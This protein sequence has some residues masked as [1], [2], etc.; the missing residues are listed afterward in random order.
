MKKLDLNIT[1]P[2]RLDK[3][4]AVS[5]GISRGAAAKAVES[6]A[7]LM[8]AAPAQTKLKITAE[9][10]ITYSPDFF[11]PKQADWDT[12]ELNILHET[13]DLLILNKQA[14]LLIHP[15]DSSHEPTLT[16][17]LVK[18]L[19]AISEVGENPIRPGLVHRLDKQASGVLAVAKTQEMFVHLKNAFKNREVIK[20]Y[21]VLVYGVIE[22]DEDEV[23]FP[24]ARSKITGR[25]A[26]K[27][28][29]QGGKEAVTNFTVKKRFHHHT[30]LDVDIKTGRTNQIRVHMFALGHQVVG[31]MLYKNTSQKP[32]PLNRLF[33]HAAELTL[34]LPDGTSQT[35]TAPLPSE[36]SDI[37]DSLPA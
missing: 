20:K 7:V 32:L 19:P 3:A 13:E 18:Y 29:E 5:L 22:R 25:M 11:A 4:V 15:T 8:N 2:T 35:F 31:D 36:L 17:A 26:A 34:P 16:E 21:E 10:D 12:P 37:L 33:L 30:L 1:E 24:I 6:G 23:N 9:A 27:T 28:L 14:G